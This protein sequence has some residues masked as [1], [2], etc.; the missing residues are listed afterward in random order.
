MDS[1]DHPAKEKAEE[2]ILFHFLGCFLFLSRHAKET[3]SG[4]L[5]EK[6]IIISLPSPV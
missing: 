2:R 5:S 1:P 3:L 6:T 4:N